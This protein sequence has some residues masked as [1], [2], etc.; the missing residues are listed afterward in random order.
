MIWKK[1]FEGLPED[2]IAALRDPF[3]GRLK[4]FFHYTISMSPIRFVVYEDETPLIAIGAAQMVL[5]NPLGE[6]WCLATKNLKVWH[7]PEMRRLYREFMAQPHHLHF[8]AA[9]DHRIPRN[10]KFARFFG[11]QEAQ[12]E[13]NMTVFEVQP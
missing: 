10:M 3:E 2:V 5:V 1:P 13:K 11:L 9:V 7:L 4:E 8:I 12:T 6:V